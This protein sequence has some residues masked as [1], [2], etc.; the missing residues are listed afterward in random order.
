VPL[1][2]DIGIISINVRSIL[3]VVDGRYE[4]KHVEF[5]G[6]VTKRLLCLTVIIY[7]CQYYLPGLTFVFC[8][9]IIS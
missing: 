1:H 6:D 2:I 3:V 8:K 7:I 5:I 9:L 4:P